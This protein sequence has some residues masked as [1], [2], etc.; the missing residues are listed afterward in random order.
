MMTDKAKKLLR[1]ADL[2]AVG[3]ILLLAGVLWLLTAGRP[4]ETAEIVCGRE[5]LYTIRLS[6]V[7]TPY[8]LRL[9]NGV[10]VTVAPGAIYFSASDCANQLCVHTGKLT[11]AGQSAACLPNKTLIRVTGCDKTAPDALTG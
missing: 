8:E 7:R 10:T 11:K 3:A 6:D 4:G 5:V 2:I 1:P 9:E